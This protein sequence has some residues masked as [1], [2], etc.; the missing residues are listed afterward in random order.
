MGETTTSRFLLNSQ[1]EDAK[2]VLKWADW[3]AANGG[4]FSVINEWRESNWF[5]TIV[6]NWPDGVDPP[7][8][9]VNGEGG[10]K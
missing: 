7:P 6:I 8:P 9:S 2:L 1:R 3:A 4:S 5:S 10:G